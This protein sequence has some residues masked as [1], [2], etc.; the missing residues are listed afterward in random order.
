MMLR[1]SFNLDKEAENIEKAVY[2]TIEDG[3]R[4]IDIMPKDKNISNLYKLV[5]CSEI[6][7]IIVSNI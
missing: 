3:Y 5:K 1:Y 6:S 7:D 2:K 4:T